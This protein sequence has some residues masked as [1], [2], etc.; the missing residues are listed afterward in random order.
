MRLLPVNKKW[1]DKLEADNDEMNSMTG[2][3]NAPHITPHVGDVVRF[4]NQSEDIEVTSIGPA[5]KESDDQ[6]FIN[7]IYEISGGLEKYFVLN[8]PETMI[9]VRTVDGVELAND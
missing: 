3:K 2:Y 6:R 9:L 8:Q 5:P 4:E 7:L 1:A